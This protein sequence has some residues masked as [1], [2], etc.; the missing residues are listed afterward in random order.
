[1][2]LRHLRCFVAVAE[3]L[4]FTRAAEWLHVGPSRGAQDVFEA[5]SYAEAL[6]FMRS[7]QTVV[8][9]VMTAQLHPY[10]VALLRK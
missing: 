2:E 10:S 6:D 7:D 9:G 1:M 8:A 3:E 4:H 5:P